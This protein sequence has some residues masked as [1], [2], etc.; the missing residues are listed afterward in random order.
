MTAS[1]AQL[2]LALLAGIGLIIVLTVRY[3][4]HAFPA[5]F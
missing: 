2:L 5:L 3:R 1:F 4:V